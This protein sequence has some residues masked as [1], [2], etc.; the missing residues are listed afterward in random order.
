MKKTIC[1][2]SIFVIF[3]ICFAFFKTGESNY[4]LNYKLK[5]YDVLEEYKNNLYV[6][7][8]N[9]NNK[10]YSYVLE[11]EYS[12]S[13]KNIDD[14]I[15]KDN[16]VS[17]SVNKEM[18]RPLCLSDDSLYFNNEYPGELI[19]KKN[20]I[21]IYNEDYRYFIWNNYGLTDLLSNKEYNF[22]NHELYDNSV[23]YQIDHYILF[24]D[25]NANY[26]YKKFYLFDIDKNKYKEIELDKEISDQ[27]YFLGD[28][29]SEVY[30][31]DKKNKTEYK[32]NINKL[33]VTK[34][35]DKNGG[36]FYDLKW[37]TKTLNEFTYNELKFNKNNIY[38]YF[39][40][41]YLYLKID[42]CKDTIRISNF[43]VDNILYQE[44]SIV[45]FIADSNIYAYDYQNNDVLLLSSFE[46][47][48]SYLGKVFIFK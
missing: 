9:V 27:I 22:V 5:E 32:I 44:G 6:Y 39:I 18:S 30:F 14:I 35:S 15:I 10:I 4:S 11:Q 21:N 3:I 41:E 28:I 26:K 7:K 23:F 42:D 12:N 25:Y 13:R 43:K 24:L 8:I 45:Y 20:N 40:D 34:V 48:F 29:D 2:I 38:N 33:K 46:W 16:C 36:P 47:N 1:F 19:D 37:T 17:I 31:F